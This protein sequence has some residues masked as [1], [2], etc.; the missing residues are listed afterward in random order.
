MYCRDTFVFR[1]SLDH[2]CDGLKRA[3]GLTALYMAKR[4]K[5]NQEN[6]LRLV[7]ESL[8]I[9]Y[10]LKSMFTTNVVGIDSIAGRATALPSHVKREKRKWQ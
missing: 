3:R 7:E 2:E 6:F 4:N 9:V 1:E 8:C 10:Q 5:K